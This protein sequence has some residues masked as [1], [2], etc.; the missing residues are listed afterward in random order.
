MPLS[1]S[2]PSK[3]P[4]SITRKYIPGAS[5]GR[6]QFLV[7]EPAAAG[8]TK[9]VEP[10]VIEHLVQPPIERMSRSF[11]Q[12]PA[13]P[14]LLLSLTSPACPH[15]HSPNLTGDWWQGQV[16]KLQRSL[17]QQ[18]GGGGWRESVLLLLAL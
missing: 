11:R 6:A 10:C 3:N 17:G 16:I 13:I 7:I 18:T 9:L 1:L 4:I 15:R 8:F 12:I 14:Q 2:I 5:D